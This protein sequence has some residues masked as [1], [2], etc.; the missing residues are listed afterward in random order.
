MALSVY[1]QHGG[2]D[3]EEHITKLELVTTIMKEGQM[4][5]AQDLLIGGDLN[6]ERKLETDG[7]GWNSNSQQPGWVFMMHDISQQWALSPTNIVLELIHTMSKQVL[8]DTDIIRISGYRKVSAWRQ[9]LD[10]PRGVVRYVVCA[11]V[12][13]RSVA[14]QK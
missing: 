13:P 10:S 9:V 3:E 5:G 1:L 8:F 4:L 6:I 7:A 11:R 12:L 14:Q 2:Y